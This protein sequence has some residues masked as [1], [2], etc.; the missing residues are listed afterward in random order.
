MFQCNL[1]SHRASKIAWVIIPHFL[2]RQLCFIVEVQIPNQYHFGNFQVAPQGP[3]LSE[4]SALP[5]IPILL[6][7][8]Q[9]SL[10]RL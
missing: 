6:S 4:E 10:K 3:S 5:I 2:P 1:F 9:Y 7:N 8:S